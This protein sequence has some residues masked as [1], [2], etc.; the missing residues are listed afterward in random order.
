MVYPVPGLSIIIWSTSPEPTSTILIN[1]SLPEA[2][3]TATVSS[4]VYPAEPSVTVAPTRIDCTVAVIDVSTSVLSIPETSAPA[5][6]IPSI[7]AKF[8]INW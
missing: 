1:A 2:L 7:E 3:E 6:N 4:I 8:S 5:T